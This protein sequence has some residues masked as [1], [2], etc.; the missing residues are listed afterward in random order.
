MS[1]DVDDVASST[2]I[3]VRL[4]KNLC[5]VETVLRNI[6]MAGASVGVLVIDSNDLGSYQREIEMNMRTF[7]N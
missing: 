4:N 1:D 5:S 7:Q 3:I 6:E 2:F